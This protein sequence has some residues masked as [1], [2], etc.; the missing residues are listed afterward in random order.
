MN[1]TRVVWSFLLPGTFKQTAVLKIWH[2]HTRKPHQCRQYSWSE[3][4]LSGTFFW[5]LFLRFPCYYRERIALESNWKIK[6]WG[7]FLWVFFSTKLIEDAATFCIAVCGCW[8]IHYYTKM[9]HGGMSKT[10]TENDKYLNLF[11]RTSPVWAPAI[12]MIR[13]LN[14]PNSEPGAVLLCS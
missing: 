5:H 1:S 12:F 2:T 9:G 6:Q 4:S 3:I 14:S 10:Q 11:S 7:F 13:N 8:D